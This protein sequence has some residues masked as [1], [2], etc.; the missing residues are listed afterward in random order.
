MDYGNMTVDAIT[1]ECVNRYTNLYEAWQALES[2]LSNQE[3]TDAVN[4]CMSIYNATNDSN[5]YSAESWDNFATAY[6]NAYDS[7]LSSNDS[8]AIYSTKN[9]RNLANN[10]E[11]AAAITAV[12]T[13]LT[14]AYNALVKLADFSALFDAASTSLDNYAYTVSDLQNLANIIDSSKYL[15]Y[16][17]DQQL[18]TTIDEQDSI[19]AETTTIKDA[20]ASLQT[21]EAI[22]V[23]ALEGVK[24]DLVA[25][26]DDPDAWT[27]IDEANELIDTYTSADKLYTAVQ[28]F[29]TSVFGINYTQ[30][31]TDEIVTE[32]MTLVQPQTYSVT[33]VDQDGQEKVYSDIPYG[34]TQEVTSIDGSQVDW[35]YSYKSNTSESTEKYYTTDSIIRFVVKGDTTLRTEPKTNTDTSQYKITIVNSLKSKVIAIDYVQSGS[36]YVLPEPTSYPYYEFT[37]YTVNGETKQAGDEITPTANTK[38]TANY[39]MDEDNAG[40]TIELAM[41]NAN[42]NWAEYEYEANYNDLVEINQDDLITSKKT[43][44]SSITVA[45][46]TQTATL[47]GFR[48]DA[49]DNDIYAYA[50]VP[51]V[52]NGVN[53][54][55]SFYNLIG[56]YIS[57]TE[58]PEGTGDIKVYTPYNDDGDDIRDVATIVGYG[59][60]YS[61]YA[62]EDT[63]IVAL[64]K[65]NY[66]DFVAA[67]IATV[68]ENG[69]DVVASSNLVSSNT[70]LSI[71]STYAIPE[72]ATLVESG[73]LFSKN[74]DSD[75]TLN[76]VDS[77]TVYRL[78]SSVHTVGNQYVIS[79]KKPSSNQNVK[80]L[81]Y[82]IYELDGVQYRVE[83]NV[84]NAT[85]E[86]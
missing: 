83:S 17:T 63:L 6:K 76:N 49:S 3:I 55:D 28:I 25:K 16:T 26:I 79:I 8:L 7:I 47:S 10:T 33:V 27:G 66:D 54:T 2:P 59:Q 71:V 20:F 68:D 78:K 80:Y 75:L 12:A 14:D 5:I 45:G 36:S 57:T 52:F 41:V 84:V 53:N 81:A 23:S 50:V 65:V 32:A 62:A 37:G 35:F 9:I 60:D 29:K 51:Y 15:K 39:E 77:K 24:A 72:G 82:M 74:L 42:G 43:V 19:D 34:T 4:T 13:A 64:T 30:D 11:N 40:I 44:K 22:D 18:T 38:I 67:G 31:N 1:D 48:R 61:F 85:F 70:D 86:A 21:K 56:D 46:E 69:A 73:I 58:D